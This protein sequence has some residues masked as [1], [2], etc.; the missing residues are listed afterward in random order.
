MIL[1]IPLSIK[2]AHDFKVIKNYQKCYYLLLNNKL[3][4][5]K[6]NIIQK[7]IKN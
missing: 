7:I 3:F 5:I 6:N 2:F 4:F 1:L